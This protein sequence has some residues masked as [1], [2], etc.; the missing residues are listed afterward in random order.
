MRVF[1]I[2]LSLLLLFSIAWSLSGVDFLQA[3]NLVSS[4]FFFAGAVTAAVGILGW[5]WLPFIAILTGTIPSILSNEF[6]L[7]DPQTLLG[8]VRVLGVYG[9]L[10][11]YL[12]YIWFL[13]DARFSVRVAI[14]FV[15]SSLIA[16]FLAAFVAIKFTHS[17]VFEESAYGYVFFSFWSGDIAGVIITVPLVYLL[18]E[19]LPNIWRERK[20]QIN[21]ESTIT[22]FFLCFLVASI[23]SFFVAW[24]PVLLS[25]RT[26]IP[27]LLFLPI[28][29]CGIRHGAITGFF[30]SSVSSL[31][32][33]LTLNLLGVDISQPID[34]YVIF[35]VGSAIALI[36]GA[37]RDDNL[38]ALAQAFIDPLTG[39]PNR[40]AIADRIEQAI[41]RAK[42]NGTQVA[43]MYLDL[44]RFKQVND[45]LGHDAGD[46]LL[47]QVTYRIK[48]SI[49]SSD[50]FGRLGGDEF[51]LIISDI[52]DSNINC[53]ATKILSEISKPFNLDGP[54]VDISASIGIAIYPDDADSLE[55]LRTIA[56]SAMY[57][58]K[59]AGRNQFYRAN[60]N[61]DNM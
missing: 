6:S 8:S 53:F 56:D 11:F 35:S 14:H 15:A 3:S 59:N 25:T 17:G 47:L 27:M 29:V 7:T 61:V 2:S 52:L 60:K 4:V 48:K 42:R 10:G 55:R 51:V 1:R 57:E 37:A 33:V 13:F 50:T 49:R 16:C 20:L 23:V 40:R 45:T 9:A 43:I 41:L 36:A 54:T 5:R 32:Y 19:Y 24:L 30:V 26:P 21:T 28:L 44:D 39:L 18:H 34:I 22:G 38:Y 46:N 31:C 58:A 12:R